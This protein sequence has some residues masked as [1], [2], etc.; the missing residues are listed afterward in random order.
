MKYCHKCSTEKLDNCF[1]KLNRSSDGLQ[2]KCKDCE[3]D[4]KLKNSDRQKELKASHYL[5]HKDKIKDR[6]KAYK[7]I[8][9]KRMRD[10][11]FKERPEQKALHNYRTRLNG[12]VKS[13][14]NTTLDLIGCSALEFK[15]YL[16]DRFVKGMSWSNYGRS[17]WHID[18][19]IPCASFDMN[20]KDD[21]KQCFH[22]TNLQPLWE[23]DNLEKGDKLTDIQLSII[24]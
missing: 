24:L 15:Q 2:S 18:H 13:K 12:I 20:N 9:R 1:Y 22:Y 8:H 6:S 5:K 23:K 7:D 14:S 17:G 4:Y 11:L 21:V 10:K 3:K 19:I 16:S